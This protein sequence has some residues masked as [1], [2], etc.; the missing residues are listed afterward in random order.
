MFSIAHA[1]CP[2]AMRTWANRI[3]PRGGSAG[4]VH[5]RLGTP[6]TY[7]KWCR[8][9]HQLTNLFR[10]VVRRFLGDRHVVDV[11]LAH[12]GRRDPNQ[13]RLALQRLDVLRAAVTHA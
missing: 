5:L 4:I 3:G 10:S 7:R 8:F 6:C 11:A 9:S 1:S 12:A 13:L 2:W